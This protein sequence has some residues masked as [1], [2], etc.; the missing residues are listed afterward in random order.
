VCLLVQQLL[1]FRRVLA[2][3]AGDYVVRRPWQRGMAQE[4]EAG[5]RRKG[6][7]G[8][9]AGFVA[10]ERT[11]LCVLAVRPRGGDVC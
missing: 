5:R 3:F 4:D 8:S 7:R 1:C 10:D 9:G 11:E 2:L 6:F